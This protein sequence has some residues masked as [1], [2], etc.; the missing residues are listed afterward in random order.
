MK[1]AIVQSGG[2]QYRCV[3]GAAI[4]VDLLAIEVGTAHTLT[5][6]LLVA[7]GKNVKIGTPTV[8]GAKVNAQVVEH[9]K[10]P[11][12]ISFRYKAKERQRSMR[13]HR[14]QY[15]RLHIESIEG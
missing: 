13:G 2:K 12:T 4:E 9:F 7:D 1:Y 3:E 10:G 8:N 6:V 15:T 11:K 5:D 14:Q